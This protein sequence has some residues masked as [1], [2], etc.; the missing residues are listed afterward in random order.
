MF[1]KILFLNVSPHSYIQTM[2]AS[3]LF[4]DLNTTVLRDCHRIR[5]HGRRVQAMQN[6]KR[7]KEI[8]FLI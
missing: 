6:F 5:C 8:Y 2:S 3:L 4:E 7:T 1:Y